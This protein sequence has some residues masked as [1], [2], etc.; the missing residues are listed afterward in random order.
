MFL[1]GSKINIQ[2]SHLLKV[3]RNCFYL[4][5]MTTYTME[6]EKK[7]CLAFIFINSYFKLTTKETTLVMQH[8]EN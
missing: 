3:C 2:D 1:R 4:L 7:V 6:E 8:I 5:S